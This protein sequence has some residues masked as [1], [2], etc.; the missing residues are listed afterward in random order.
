VNY[1]KDSFGY[2]SARVID[3]IIEN[4]DTAFYVKFFKKKGD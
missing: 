3:T 2:D 4:G 1:W